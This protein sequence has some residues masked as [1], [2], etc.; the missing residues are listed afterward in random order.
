MY[1]K[2]HISKVLDRNQIYVKLITTIFL[3]SRFIRINLDTIFWI[4]GYE[5]SHPFDCITLLNLLNRSSGPL[6]GLWESHFSQN[7]IKHQ[8]WPNWFNW[9]CLFIRIS[10][11]HCQRSYCGDNWFVLYF[12]FFLVLPWSFHPCFSTFQV[13]SLTRKARTFH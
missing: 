10:P 6:K 11:H 3:K 4:M 9:A 12:I 1:H 8:I 2:A 7:G 5:F 13:V